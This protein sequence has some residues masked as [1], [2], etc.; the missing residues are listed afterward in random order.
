M[1]CLCYDCGHLM[2]KEDALVRLKGES[3]D[4]FTET[5]YEYRCTNCGSEDVTDDSGDILEKYITS[6]VFELVSS[7]IGTMED[8]S[9]N[10]QE[11]GAV[12]AILCLLESGRWKE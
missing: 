10:A 9:M 11:D 7:V 6:D 4:G 3:I 12:D 5:I 1:K 8:L 2:D